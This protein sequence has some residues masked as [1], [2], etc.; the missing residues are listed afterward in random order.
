VDRI[1]GTE[2][3]MS[4]AITRLV[5]GYLAEVERAAADLPR[6][7]RAELLADLE[8]HILAELGELKPQTVAGTR[9]ILDRLGDPYVIAEEARHDAPPAFPLPGR[10]LEP[11]SKSKIGVGLVVGVAVAFVALMTVCCLGLAAFQL[12]SPKGRTPSGPPSPRPVEV[13]TTAV[14]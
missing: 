12:V 10:T 11:P 13:S 9:E 8:E 5:T 4:E 7:R 6:R 1:V 3:Q 2:G 14:P